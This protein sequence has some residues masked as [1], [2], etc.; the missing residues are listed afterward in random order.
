MSFDGEKNDDLGCRKHRDGCSAFGEIT[1]KANTY[2]ETL[3][4]EQGN[5][6][7]H[8]QLIIV[9]VSCGIFEHARVGILVPA[10]PFGSC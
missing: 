6:Q 10:N 4:Y 1:A 2:G 5:T 3:D 9:L 8:G 7:P